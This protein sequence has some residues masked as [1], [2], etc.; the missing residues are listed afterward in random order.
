MNNDKERIIE[1]ENARWSKIFQDELQKNTK[2]DFSS[3]WWE[4]YYIDLTGY[5]NKKMLENGYTT[6]LEAGSGSGKTTILTDNRFHKTLL[7]ISP[8]AL[9]YAKYLANKF[10]KK[11][12]IFVG[13]DMFHMPFND[14]EFN[15]VWNIGTVEHYEA[16]DIELAIRE[17][18]RVCTK[19]G[20]VAVGIPNRF[21]GPILKAWL[22]KKIKLIPGYKLDTEYFYS[23]TE[24]Q[25]IF[26]RAIS[27][28]NKKVEYIEVKYFGNPL[29]I[30]TPKIILKT[31]GRLVEHIFPKS[32]FLILVA[33][34]LK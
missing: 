14:N 10:D 11:D 15:L 3:Y 16:N 2:K 18:I 19:D 24:I 21:S 26:D 1:H 8:T 30:E 32:K 20:I 7:D 25:K 28:S 29:I 13:G 6:I 27:I 5:V 4:N 22:L 33:C 34:K 17:M 23:A 9:R 31:I 12:V